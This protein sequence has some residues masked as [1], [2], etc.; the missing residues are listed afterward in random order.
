MIRVYH[1]SVCIFQTQLGKVFKSL[2]NIKHFVVRSNTVTVDS[3]SHEGN[4]GMRGPC[5]GAHLPGWA[6]DK[7]VFDIWLTVLLNV[8]VHEA[9]IG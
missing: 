2:K 4:E 3:R 7:W 9:F 6:S 8:S 1:A 5:Y